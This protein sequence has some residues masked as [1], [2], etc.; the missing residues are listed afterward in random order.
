[1]I[2]SNSA[3]ASTFR[4]AM[5][6][7]KVASDTYT[8]AQGYNCTCELMIMKL[9]TWYGTMQNAMMQCRQILVD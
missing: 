4:I 6:T 8:L 5:D 9:C 7:F 1:M 3:I 2:N